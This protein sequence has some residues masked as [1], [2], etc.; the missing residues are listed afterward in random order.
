MPENA[1]EIVELITGVICITG[2]VLI[3]TVIMLLLRLKAIDRSQKKTKEM[4]EKIYRENVED[5]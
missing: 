2:C 3:P 5:E 4:M 1:K